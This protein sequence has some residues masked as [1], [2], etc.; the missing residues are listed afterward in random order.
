[1][2]ATSFTGMPFRHYHITRPQCATVTCSLFV[3][4]G[5]SNDLAGKEG[6]AHMLEHLLT[7][8]PQWVALARD[9]FDIRAFTDR[10]FCVFMLSVPASQ[11]SKANSAFASLF[12]YPEDGGTL[13]LCRRQVLAE[14]LSRRDDPVLSLIDSYHACRRSCVLPYSETIGSTATIEAINDGDLRDFHRR[15]FRPE[16]SFFV[17]IGTAPPSLQICSPASN[18]PDF[19]D[20]PRRTTHSLVG[21][22]A[23]DSRR[24]PLVYFL[25]ASP[26][27][28][29]NGRDARP[30]RGL[31]NLLSLR[32]ARFSAD[33]A[34]MLT[35][36][37]QLSFDADLIYDRAI[38]TF[39]AGTNEYCRAAIAFMMTIFADLRGG[40]VDASELATAIT[41]YLTTRTL[42]HADPGLAS[43]FVAEQA[44]ANGFPPAID[45]AAAIAKHRDT[46]ADEVAA[47]ARLVMR[48]ESLAYVGA[49]D[50]LLAD[51]PLCFIHDQPAPKRKEANG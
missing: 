50:P 44:V 17:T 4:G 19:I 39:V 32:A 27:G 42:R 34:C 21:R 8:Q 22:C 29:T 45:C 35:D 13:Q 18:M 11:I 23:W 51:F 40:S 49:G 25:F 47:C 6:T 41:R 2:I 28:G 31:L 30:L 14:L 26:I 15:Y 36:P 48:P 16:H 33:R 12:Q 10:S 5:S 46:T 37:G 9:G 3:R 7:C 20:P 1:M 24:S 38:Y 43:C